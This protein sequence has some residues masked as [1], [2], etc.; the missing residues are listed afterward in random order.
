M[1][2]TKVRDA[3]DQRSDAEPA[4]WAHRNKSCFSSSLIYGTEPSTS[5]MLS[6]G[7]LISSACGA[8]S[9]MGVDIL[10][11]RKL[12][13]VRP[14]LLPRRRSPHRTFRHRPS[15]PPLAE[16]WPVCRAGPGNKVGSQVNDLSLVHSVNT[17]SMPGEGKRDLIRVR[18]VPCSVSTLNCSERMQD[19]TGRY[20]EAPGRAEKR[21]TSRYT[22]D[23][24]LWD[25]F[26][27]I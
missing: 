16:D 22:C 8:L 17:M 6:G 2:L 26:R 11:L 14:W 20:L 12:R 23:L 13:V 24:S 9:S 7:H 18:V 10:F 15:A 5:Y 1:G 21:G 19:R 4:P 25:F 3:Q 27:L